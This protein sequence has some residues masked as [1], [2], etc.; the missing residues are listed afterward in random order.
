[1][2]KTLIPRLEKLV[3]NEESHLKMLQDNNADP[4]MIHTSSAY[5]EHYKQRLREYL[6]YIEKNEK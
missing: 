3:V 5:L 2:F 6:D 4:T 1:M